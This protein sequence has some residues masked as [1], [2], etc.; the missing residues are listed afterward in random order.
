MG[1]FH[2]RSYAWRQGEFA[3]ARATRFVLNPGESLFV[4]AGWWHT[5]RLLSA[6]IS[7]SVNSANAANWRDFRRDFCAGIARDR[8]SL[9]ARLTGV[10][11]TLL[12]WVL[13]TLE[14][15]EWFL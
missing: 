1:V 5:T 4:P 14:M 8:G 13:S 11:L 2:M 10:Y 3:Q 15:L 9:R 12:G 7:V 6:T